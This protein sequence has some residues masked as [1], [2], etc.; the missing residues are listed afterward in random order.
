MDV[1]TAQQL[2]RF[3]LDN[4]LVSLIEVTTQRKYKAGSR[5]TYYSAMKKCLDDEAENLTLVE[6]LMIEVAKEVKS[7]KDSAVQA[8]PW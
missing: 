7:D 5:S 3:I 8:L 4:S 1:N 6:R 2:H